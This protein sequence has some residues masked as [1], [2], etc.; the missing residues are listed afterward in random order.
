MKHSLSDLLTYFMEQSPFWE[1]NKFS[2]SQEFHCILWN[3]KIHYRIQKCP[4]AIPILS[5]FDS[6]NTPTSHFLQIHLTIV[7]PSTLV[8]SKWSLSL[9]FP[10]QNPIYSSPLPIRAT[11]PTHLILLYFITRTIMGEEYRS[12]I[13]KS[14]WP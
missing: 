4:P 2:A 13:I 7:F 12:L 14:F 10:N 8:S 11:C 5:Q 6:V 3:P 9:R 1:A